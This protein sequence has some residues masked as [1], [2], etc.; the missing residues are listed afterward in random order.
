VAPRSRSLTGRIRDQLGFSIAAILILFV[1]L[2]FVGVRSTVGSIFFSIIITIVLNVGLSYYYDHRARKDRSR[3]G[4]TPRRGGG[5][6]RFR[7]D[8]H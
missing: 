3:G 5:D 1:V 6:I 4:P 8:D 2:R 7:D